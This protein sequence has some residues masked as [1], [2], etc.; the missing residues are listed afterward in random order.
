[1]LFDLFY[2]IHV[3]YIRPFMADVVLLIIIFN[4]QILMQVAS[5][6]FRFTSSTT[7]SV[8]TVEYCSI[9]FFQGFTGFYGV[10]TQ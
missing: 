2:C 3:L 10:Y 8:H 9:S 6:C 1:M 7:S 4:G 5:C